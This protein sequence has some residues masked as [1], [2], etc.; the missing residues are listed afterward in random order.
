MKFYRVDSHKLSNLCREIFKGEGL[1]ESSASD[2]TDLLIAADLRGV[3]SHGVI[4]VKKYLDRIKS[5]GANKDAD[6]KIVRETPVTAVLDAEDG[7]GGVASARAV[8][9]AR[10]KA[11]NNGIGLVTV[12]NSNHFGMAGHWALALAGDNMLGFCGSNTS[13]GMPPPGAIRAGIGNNPFAFA[14]SGRKYPDI[15]VDMASSIVAMGK[16]VDLVKRGQPVPFGWFLDKDGKDSNDLK[17]AAMVLPFA[18]HKGY[19]VAFIVETLSSLLA[20]GT[21]PHLMND[22]MKGDL[23]ERASQYC[24][25]IRIDCFRPV[26]DFKSDVDTYIDFLKSLPVKEGIDTVY[27][28]GEIEYNHKEEVLAQG[29]RLPETLTD[30]LRAIAESYHLDPSL[31]LCLTEKAE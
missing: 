27:Y 26:D 5:G 22:Q 19:G 9:M 8:R 23:P 2:V 15:C 13:P 12:L 3:R 11:E 29:I 6:M 17:E 30:E 14:Y 25:A 31:I 21:L 7:L 24:M 28:P 18:G 10:E 1:D 20:G 4:R 16:V